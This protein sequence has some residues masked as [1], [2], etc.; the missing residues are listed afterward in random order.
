MLYRIHVR[1][2]WMPGHGLIPTRKLS[3][4]LS[5]DKTRMTWRII[6]LVTA[7][8]RM[9][10]YCHEWVHVV[11]NN[12]K[13]AHRSQVLLYGSPYGVNELH[14]NIIHTI[15]LVHLIARI[16]MEIGVF[17]NARRCDGQKNVIR[18]TMQ[19]SSTFL[20]SNYDGHGPI[21]GTAGDDVLQQR[22][23]IRPPAAKAHTKQCTR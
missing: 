3:Y 7:I 14:K 9:E 6:M 4:P 10:H 19:F 22:N 21:A 15:I 1:S 8:N 11:C 16:S 23:A 12:V 13:V 20:W 18:Q 17:A 2:I 5:V